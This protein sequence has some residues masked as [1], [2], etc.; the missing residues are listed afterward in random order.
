MSPAHAHQKEVD[1]T[2]ISTTAIILAAALAFLLGRCAY[3]SNLRAKRLTTLKDDNK[4]LRHRLDYIADSSKHNRF[5][6]VEED[7]LSDAYNVNLKV[8][9]RSSTYYGETLDTVCYCLIKSFPFADDKD[10]ALLSAQ[11]LLDK[12][13]EK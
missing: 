5:Y 10:F 2:I 8:Y 12:L 7:E 1:M 4:K 3:I 11:E 9:I 6:E 13:N